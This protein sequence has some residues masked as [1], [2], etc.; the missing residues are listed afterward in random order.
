MLVFLFLLN[1]VLITRACWVF[2]DETV[3]RGTLIAGTA[4]QILAVQLL[5]GGYVIL[6]VVAAIALLNLLTYF[7]DAEMQ[8]QPRL[9]ARL[10]ILV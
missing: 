10:T 8:E 3:N 7:F 1:A 9:V 6:Y 4:I 2:K 5:Q